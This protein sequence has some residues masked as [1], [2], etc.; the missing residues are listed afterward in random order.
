MQHALKLTVLSVSFAFVFA[1]CD[2]APE[3]EEDEPA[4]NGNGAERP[5]KPAQKGEKDESTTKVSAPGLA[6]P[7]DWNQ[8]GGS[9]IRNNTPDAKNIP[10]FFSTVFRDG[11]FTQEEVPIIDRL[12]RKPMVNPE[13]GEVMTE[14]SSGI[15]Y[16]V[17]LGSQ[18]YGNPVVANG[19]LYVGTNNGNGYIKRYPAD[20]DLGCLICFRESD[21]KFLWQHSSEK[22]ED[23]RVRDWPLQGICCAPLVEGDR[24]WYTTSRGTIVC[25]DTEGFAD[26]EDDGAKDIHT[27]ENEADVIWEFDMIARTGLFQ[28]NMCSCS[29]VGDGDLLFV[30]TGNGVDESHLNI[31][32]PDA[33]SFLCLSKTSGKLHWSDKSPGTNIL[34]GQW[35]SPSVATVGG[36]KQVFFAGGDAWLYSFKANEGKDGKPELL[37]KFDAN[38]KQSEYIL[39][40]RGTRNEIIGTPVIYK[41]MVYIA[42]GQDPEHGE[43]V[44]HLWCVDPTKRGDVSPELVVDEDNKVIPHRRL[45]AAEE[46]DRVV[47]NPNS[48]LVWHYSWQDQ[49]GDGKEDYEEVM[50]RSCGTVA[51]KDDILYVADFSGVFH[52]LDALTGKVHW[53]HDMLSASWGS[54]LIVDGK[55]YIGDEDGDVSVFNH[56]ADPAKAMQEIEY[57]RNKK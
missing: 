2:F 52:C 46:G 48:A 3:R 32:A 51:I 35:S 18:T 57:V 1:G 56:S 45:Q 36:V 53:T 25:L 28:H 9:Q 34:H 21:G 7:H 33:P 23:G 8:W 22:L 37:W 11:K 44:G 4:K 42:V 15:K 10:V 50:H 31:P 55:V 30:I 41:D 6:G 38:P 17:P 40:G 39:G 16:G 12:T 27:G 24:L 54:P 5:R 20:V 14:Q 19:K 26:G 13:T 29:V 43:G 47:P 49:N